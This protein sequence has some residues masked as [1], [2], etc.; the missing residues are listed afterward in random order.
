MTNFTT[1]T[2]PFSVTINHI[3]DQLEPFCDVDLQRF[4]ERELLRAY[5]VASGWTEHSA[6]AQTAASNI[7]GEWQARHNQ[8]LPRIRSQVGYVPK[9]QTEVDEIW[10]GIQRVRKHR[11]PL[12]RLETDTYAH[13]A[14][15]ATPHPIY[16]SH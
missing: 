8:S 4:T 11:R 6:T 16:P 3:A 14:R 15:E 12:R 1:T 10:S 9:F 5:D 7:A 2:D 13:F